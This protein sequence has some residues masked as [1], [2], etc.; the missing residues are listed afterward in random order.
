MICHLCNNENPDNYRF[1]RNCGA[2]FINAPIG[3]DTLINETHPPLKK[4]EFYQSLG[5]CWALLITSLVSSC[6]SGGCCICFA[7]LILLP[8][9]AV[10]CYFSNPNADAKAKNNFLII[11]II[12]FVI[13]MALFLLIICG[14]ILA[15]LFSGLNKYK[16]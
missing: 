15:G 3:A 12:V 4:E 9:A 8:I 10:L 13:N 2:E 1:C 5:F 11:S 7:P 14:G 16:Y 6:I